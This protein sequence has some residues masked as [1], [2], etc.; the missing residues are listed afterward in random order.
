ML[1]VKRLKKEYL[2]LQNEPVPLAVAKPIDS[3]ILEW[4]FLIKGSDD[5]EGGYYHG[6]L[7]FPPQYPMKPPGIMFFTPSGRFEIN[8]RVCL[9]IS[10]FHP[11]TWSPL[12]TVGSILTGI[13]SFMNSDEITTGGLAASSKHRKAFAASSAAYNARDQVYSELF[14]PNSPSEIFEEA[15]RKIAENVTKRMELR[16]NP[17]KYSEASR[18][19]EIKPAALGS[20]N[21]IPIAT[22]ASN[23]GGRVAFT[24]ISV[25]SNSGSDSVAAPAI[26]VGEAESKSAGLTKSAKKRMKEKERALRA[27]ELGPGVEFSKL[28]SFT[29]ADDSDDE[30]DNTLVGDEEDCGVEENYPSGKFSAEENMK[31]FTAMKISGDT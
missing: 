22:S 17:Q 24:N 25:K 19:S 7:I 31:N 11:E 23:S 15:D 2:T 3:N 5:Y 16:D 6:K 29:S 12:W 10:D 21:L 1:S 26:T 18:N 8:K 4:R 30:C 9:T 13:V 14:G 20:P 27:K 28:E